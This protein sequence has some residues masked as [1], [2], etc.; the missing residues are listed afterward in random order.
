MAGAIFV[1][2]RRIVVDDGTAA[3]M[4]AKHA[5]CKYCLF[6]HHYMGI[7]DDIGSRPLSDEKWGYGKMPNGQVVIYDIC[8]HHRKHGTDWCRSDDDLIKALDRIPLFSLN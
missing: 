5:V 4:A 7:R 3:A 8:P 6:E 1:E 2:G